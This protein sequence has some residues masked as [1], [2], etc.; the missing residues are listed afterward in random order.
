MFESSID[1]NFAPGCALSLSRGR[2]CVTMI[3][4]S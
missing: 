1:F 4:I 3:G 2:R